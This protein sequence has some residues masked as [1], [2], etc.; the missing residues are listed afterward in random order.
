MGAASRW[1]LHE[2][3][4]ALDESLGS[5]LRFFRGA[6]DK[7]LP[8]IARESGATEIYWNRCYEQWRITRDSKLKKELQGNGL[9][10]RSYNGSLLFEPQNVKKEPILR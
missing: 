3:L 7:L 10:V 9:L 1:W 5:R 6:A 8:Q 4:A 2:S